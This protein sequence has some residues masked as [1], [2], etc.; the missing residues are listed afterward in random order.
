MIVLPTSPAP[1]MTGT[2]SMLSSFCLSNSTKISDSKIVSGFS[3]VGFS[4]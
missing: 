3:I 1:I 4:L 2:I